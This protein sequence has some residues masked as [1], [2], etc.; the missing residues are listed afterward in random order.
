MPKGRIPEEKMSREEF[1]ERAE[2]ALVALEYY[3]C[4]LFQVRPDPIELQRVRRDLIEIV[5]IM[6][7]DK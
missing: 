6:S 5:A 2:K 1:S 3:I 4:E 7:E